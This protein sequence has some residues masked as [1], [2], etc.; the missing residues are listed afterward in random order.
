MDNQQRAEQYLQQARE[1]LF[2][3]F[4]E[5][6]ASAML[7][8]SGVR[9]VCD[10]EVSRQGI[11]GVAQES[12]QIHI[13]LPA[14]FFWAEKYKQHLEKLGRETKDPHVTAMAVLLAEE[15]LHILLRHAQRMRYQIDLGRP[16]LVVDTAA[17]VEIFT[18]LER[19]GFIVPPD[20]P[21][22]WGLGLP[23]DCVTLEQ[24]CEYLENMRRS[25]LLESAWG[26][27]R[28]RAVSLCADDEEKGDDTQKG[29]EGIGA[30]GDGEGQE[31]L[32]PEEAQAL[33]SF[34]LR[35]HLIFTGEGKTPPITLLTTESVRGFLS[36]PGLTAIGEQIFVRP[37]PEQLVYQLAGIFRNLIGMG[38]PR[39]N[40]DRFQRKMYVATGL[41]LP[42]TERRGD[43]GFVV[44]TSGS[45]MQKTRSTARLVDRALSIALSFCPNNV[46]IVTCDAQ[47][48]APFRPRDYRG[49]VKGGG[50]TKLWEGVKALF[51]REKYPYLP[52]AYESVIIITDGHSNWPADQEIES[53]VRARSSTLWGLVVLHASGHSPRFPQAV[54]RHFRIIYFCV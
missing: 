33:Q 12:G 23:E 30:H 32:T 16:P 18:V 40:P 50:G 19:M 24:V 27:V 13:F 36:Q 48:Y 47:G 53:F 5:G 25:P 46:W 10:D 2:A 8:I 26:K 42:A 20:V 41:V 6:L 38:R 39:V 37:Q 29:A 7:I 1:A 28:S 34:P 45:M 3:R 22:R 15:I 49:V 51:D 35:P 11:V 9:V 4:P 43:F 44:D 52:P 17:H 21:T 14:F 54:L 31:T